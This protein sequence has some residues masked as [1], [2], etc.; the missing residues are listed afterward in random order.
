MP[1]TGS[2]LMRLM[3][4]HREASSTIPRVRQGF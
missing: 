1:G 4:A 3:P 2:Q